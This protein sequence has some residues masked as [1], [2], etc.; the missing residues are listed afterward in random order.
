MSLQTAITG[1]MVAQTGIDTT[2]NNLANANTTAYKSQTALFE[3]LF[4][5]E[6]GNTKPGTGASVEGMSDDLTEGSLTSTGNSLDAA[7][8]GNGYF[9]IS[10]NGTQQYTRDGAFQLSNTG[11]IETLNGS[12]VQGYFEV[13]G[14]LSGSLGALMVNTGSIGATATSNVGLALNLNS[15]TSATT[16]TVSPVTP[17]ATSSVS[18]AFN[19][20]S[21]ATAISK[22]FSATDSTTYT[23]KVTP[24]V[25]VYDASGNAN[26]IQF[27]TQYTGNNIWKVYAVPEDAN[28]GAIPNATPAETTMTFNPSTGA[29]ESTNQTTPLSVKWSGQSVASPINLNFSGSLANQTSFSVAS[30]GQNG[31]GTSVPFV[32]S[33]SVIAYDAQGNA[34]RVQLYTVPTGTNSWKVY[35]QPET[36][37]GTQLQGQLMATLNFNQNGT[38]TS[39]TNAQ[40]AVQQNNAASLSVQWPGQ[41]SS[42]SI[43]FNFAGTTLQAQSFAVSSLTNNGSAPGAYSGVSI[44]S[45]G[46]VEASYTNGQTLSVGKIAIA[47]FINPE[48]LTPMSGNLYA[49]SNSSGTP[50]VSQAGTGQA[51][52]LKGGELEASNVSTSNMLVSLIQYQQAYEANTS[53]IQTEQQ[54]SQRLLQI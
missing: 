45:D 48:G 31:N 4:P 20:P 39:V 33:T 16:G 25:T 19:L 38:L 21:G 10:S 28:G 13:N 12:P 6:N 3:S 50:V 17:N 15:S 30:S 11:Q 26:Q 2:S 14:S 18:T 7:I 41:T 54:D 35:A 40:G 27:Y 1:L 22:A 46:S 29:L 49:Q 53:V 47:N 8:E 51:G 24:A 34:N 43:S 42:S 9:V 36:S 44:G 23:D 37:T 52:T 32:N 5:Q